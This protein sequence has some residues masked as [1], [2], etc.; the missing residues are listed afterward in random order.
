MCLHL[1][2][3][4]VTHVSVLVSFNYPFNYRHVHNG[5]RNWKMSFDRRFI[6]NWFLFI[7]YYLSLHYVRIK[8]VVS[9]VS[10][11]R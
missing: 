9:C 8:L 1:R 10:L 7:F 3:S 6:Q 2:I 4:A 5:A 11:H